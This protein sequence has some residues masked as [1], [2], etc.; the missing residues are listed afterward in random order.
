MQTFLQGRNGDEEDADLPRYES[1][2]ARELGF[3]LAEFRELLAE[4]AC[5]SLPEACSGQAREN[6]L[7]GL[8][9]PDLLL[10]R[11]CARGFTGAWERFLVLYREKLYRAARAIAPEESLARELADSLYAELY[12]M[13]AAG[14][15]LRVSK[16]NSYTGRGSLEGWL[17]TVL[18]Q[19][20]VN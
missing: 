14:D 18:A 20:Y 3:S 12:G 5:R 19:E 2:G 16:L 7:D 1:C 13:K 6:F 9:L 10:A 8:R 11:A 17:K 15:G 4:I